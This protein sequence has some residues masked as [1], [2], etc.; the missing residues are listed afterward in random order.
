MKKIYFLIFIC[1]II[2][3][4]SQDKN[5]FNNSDYDSSEWFNPDLDR[6]NNQ[7]IIIRSIKSSV[8]NH[9][10][11]DTFESNKI[12]PFYNFQDTMS[13]K[14]FYNRMPWLNKT[15]KN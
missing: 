5:K 11:D 14:K 12:L 7:S 15:I 4:Y 10:L 6:N 13:E 8:L 9:R 1:Q 3:G 2:P